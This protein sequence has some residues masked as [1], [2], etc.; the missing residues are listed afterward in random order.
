MKIQIPKP[1]TIKA[2]F[3][4]R[5]GNKLG[6]LT[7]EEVHELFDIKNRRV[8]ESQ[9]ISSRDPICRTRISTVFLGFDHGFGPLSDHSPILFETIIFGN[10]KFENF[11]IRYCTESEALAGHNKIVSLIQQG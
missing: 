2:G 10:K 4:D 3:Y 1:D 6:E 9:I 7:P 11:Q 8:A 5:Q